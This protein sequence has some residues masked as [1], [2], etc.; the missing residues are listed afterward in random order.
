MKTAI[1]FFNVCRVLTF[2]DVARIN[3]LSLD[4]CATLAAPLLNELRGI[5]AVYD[6]PEARDRA[7]IAY[8]GTSVYDDV[9]AARERTIDELAAARRLLLGSASFGVVESIERAV[10]VDRKGG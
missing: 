2:N 6:G 3:A 5:A 7:G 9:I 1:P 10:G 4:D 8:R